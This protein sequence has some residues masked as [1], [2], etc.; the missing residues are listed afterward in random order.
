VRLSNALPA[1][2][3]LSAAVALSEDVM[4]AALDDAGTLDKQMRDSITTAIEKDRRDT[5]EWL[6][7]SPTSYLATVQRVD[8]ENR[9]VLTLGREEDNDIRIDDPEVSA[10]HLS[11]TVIADSFRVEAVDP[12]ARFSPGG[13][14]VRSAI[15]GPSSVKVGRFIIRL[16]HQRFPALIVFDPSSERFGE[17]KGLKYFPVDLAYRYVLDLIAN[18][19]MDTVVIM[20]TR[21]NSRHALRVGWFEFEAGKKVCRLEVHRLLEPGVSEKSY[22]VFFRDLTS[23]N[24]TYPVGRYVEAEML[25]DGRFL[26]DFNAA[27]NP[28]CAFSPHYN[29]PLPPRANDLPVR[30]PAGE[31]NAH[32]MDH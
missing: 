32:Y 18:P 9:T 29:C 24:E 2:A 5:E 11:V 7:T 12:G 30:I 26:V 28:A 27:Y 31:M 15:V 23:G 1:I 25:P 17:Y 6:K 10:H 4:F 19:L 22:S 13:A 20:S 14:P 8:F 16:S 21:G 3:L